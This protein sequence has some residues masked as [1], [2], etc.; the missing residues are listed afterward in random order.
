MHVSGEL[1]SSHSLHTELKPE[2]FTIRAGTLRIMCVSGKRG[3]DQF[4]LTTYKSE[5]LMFHNPRKHYAYNVPGG[6][7]SPQSSQFS[8][9]THESKL[10]LDSTS[11]AS[12]TCSRTTGGFTSFG[13]VTKCLCECRL[14]ARWWIQVCPVIRCPEVASQVLLSVPRKYG[15]GN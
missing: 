3:T 7:I 12:C 4:S 9:V 10:P 5:A 1:S 11:E 15:V 8:S 2:C 6:Q 13:R 14:T